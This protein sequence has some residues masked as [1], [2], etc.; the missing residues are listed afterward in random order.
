MFTQRM[1][2]SLLRER[3]FIHINEID[4]VFMDML[5]IEKLSVEIAGRKILHDVELEIPSGEV[6]VIFG[7]NGS[8][9]SS[10]IMSILGHPAYKVV[11]GRII[12]DGRDITNLPLNERVKLGLGVAYQSP[13]AVKG[14]KL[15]TIVTRLSNEERILGLT[16]SLN[17]SQEILER[18]LNV[19]FSGGEIKRS[20]ILQVMAQN[21]KFAIFDEPDSGV[22]VENLHAIGRI[23][24]EFLE[25]RSG[26]LVTHTGH[27][28][29]HVRV[30]RAHVIINGTVACSGDPEK[31][32]NQIM[33]N[34][35]KWCEKCLEKRC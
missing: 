34:G 15:K 24:G 6:H 23:I 14:V 29:K 33:R 16:R 13:P 27:I 7:P 35:Y 1:L 17:L 18:D 20:E 22:D 30:H 2:I 31:I 21:P 4:R 5:K 12:F 9:K 32:F 28:L 3:N 8:G 25:E 19:G 11:S 26:L 10:L